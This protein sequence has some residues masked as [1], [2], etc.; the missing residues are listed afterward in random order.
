[1]TDISGFTCDNCGDNPEDALPEGPKKSFGGQLPKEEPLQ[2]FQDVHGG[3][4]KGAR[5][6]EQRLEI[7]ELR[8]LPS[9]SRHVGL[10]LLTLLLA[11]I[12]RNLGVCA[13]NLDSAAAFRY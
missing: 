7:K 4:G 9:Y 3:S 2:A 12:K 10:P 1:M 13:N 11:V 5:E 6:A 8:S